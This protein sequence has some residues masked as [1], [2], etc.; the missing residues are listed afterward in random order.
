MWANGWNQ[1]YYGTM[2]PVGWDGD[3]RPLPVNEPGSESY[4]KKYMAPKLVDIQWAIYCSKVHARLEKETIQIVQ[5]MVS[6]EP[7][8]RWQ[9]FFCCFLTTYMLMSYW[10]DDN[11]LYGWNNAHGR[12][13]DVSGAD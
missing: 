11:Y 10:E 7:S 4:Y 8:R 12:Y 5:K 2:D 1:N 3:D 13:A 6:G 9:R